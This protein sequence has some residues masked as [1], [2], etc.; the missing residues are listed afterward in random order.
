[1]D[2]YALNYDSSAT[3]MGQCFY[4]DTTTQIVGCMDMY[5]LN[6]DS[7]ATKM[8][9]CFYPDTTQ[10]VGCMDMYALNFNVNATISGQ[11]NYPDT[12]QVYLTGDILGCTDIK[13]NNY[14]ANATKDNGSCSYPIDYT[15]SI[16]G[17]MDNTAL[18]Y[19]PNATIQNSSCI[20]EQT[21]V[22]LPI[23]LPIGQTISDELA[24]TLS[25]AC[26]VDFTRLIDSAVITKAEITSSNALVTWVISQGLNT[27]TI[28]TT[29]DLST[30][31]LNPQGNYL[32]FATISCVNPGT[33]PTGSSGVE[34]RSLLRP[35]TVTGI[36]SSSK[37][38][39]VQI[40]P[41]PVNDV[42]TINAT[43]DVESIEIFNSN[44]V[45][46]LSQDNASSVNTTSLTRGVYIIKVIDQNGRI[47]TKQF[48]KN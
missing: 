22:Y 3:K 12:N 34:L 6:Y 38:E 18:N 35:E 26:E 37:V 7:S 1:M 30:I 47:N 14:K 15:G 2:M 9:Q 17:C 48:V 42:L 21:S 24:T 25:T 20:F 33:R 41:N 16:A 44:G 39:F 10:I 4:P 45:S 32:L 8:G 29:Y 23:I 27:V 40:L 43:V 5:A 36:F 11:C 31:K 19:N 13:A 46:V 28:E